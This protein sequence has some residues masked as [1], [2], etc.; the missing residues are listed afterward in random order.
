MNLWAPLLPV[1][2][3]LSALV[4]DG[5]AQ[6]EPFHPRTSLDGIWEIRRDG[7]PDESYRPI[8]V[9]G[10]FE[11]V[12]GMDFDGVARY[13]RTLA[14]PKKR[15]NKVFAEFA[16]VATHARVLVNGH[17]VKEHLGGW[18]P[19]RA[20]LTQHLKWNGKD[21]LEVIVDERVGHNTQGF[22]PIVQ[23]HFGGI[24]QG[25]TLCCSDTPT[26]DRLNVFVFGNG[27]GEVTVTTG[28]V[29]TNKQP[30][31]LRIEVLDGDTVVASQTRTDL[32]RF[33]DPLV[34]ASPRLWRPGTPHLYTA[35]LSLLI[36]DK[37]VDTMER[38]FGCRSLRANGTQVVWNDSPLQMRGILHW[39][40][41]PPA[42]APPCDPAY[43]RTQLEYFQSLGFNTIKCCLWVP[44]RGF[45][46]L[47]DELGMLV[48][49]EY[50]T[51]HAKMDQDHKRELLA[52]YDEFFRFDRSHPSVAFR[53]ITCE[54][55]KGADL[56][57]VT[58]LFQA[59]KTMVPDTLVV[60]DSS[61]IGWQ[62]I[63]DFWDEHPY[64]NNS[65]FPGRLKEFQNHIAENGE[66]PLLLGECIAA[67]TWVDR[68]AWLAMHGE[69]DV[70]WR[71]RC[72]DAQRGAEAWLAKEFG[73]DL[74][75]SLNDT[76]L[77]FGLRNRR[78]QIE[79]LRLKI[80][81]AGYVVSVA[82]D[83]PKARMG[84]LDDLNRPKWHADNWQWHRDTMLCLAYGNQRAIGPGDG[85]AVSI[86][87]SHFGT[88]P[89][90]G[91]L[92]AWQVGSPRSVDTRH[93][94]I[95]ALPP[96]PIDAQTLWRRGGTARVVFPPLGPKSK[97]LERIRIEAELSGTHPMKSHWHLWH[98]PGN[99][100][101]ENRNDVIEAEVL[102][103]D[104]IA[105]MEAGA[106][107]FLRVR[108]QQ[109]SL[110]TESMWFLKGA[111]FAPAHA[112]HELLPA[113]CLIET[114]SFDLESGRVIPWLPWRE[115][116]DPILAFWETHDIDAVRF[117]LH[118]FDTRVGK[119]RLMATSLKLDGPFGE[120]V[121]DLMM[122]HL[123]NGS[124]PRRALRAE[125]IQALKAKLHE[126]TIELPTWRF[127]MD[128][129]NVGQKHN[130]H[131]PQLDATTDD[132]R[133]LK[134]GSH[135]ENQGEDLKHFTGVGWYRVDVDVPEDW[136][137]IHAR[138]VLDGVD[139]SFHIWLNGELIGV[140]GDEASKTTIWL[141]QQVAE[142]QQRLQPGERNTIVLRVVDHAGAG[143][144]WKP[145]RLTTGPAGKV[146]NLLR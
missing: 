144:L 102:T 22:L 66:K 94:R 26:L 132:W 9:P 130:W 18:T 107:V 37:P 86:A 140:F 73:S 124:A 21:V 65:W 91:K 97:K 71:P 118:A 62:R 48:W 123:I 98:F 12:L 128:P 17:Q 14:L 59:C 143:G 106:K 20:D 110:R 11:T 7:E 15:T 95:E 146:S 40:Y 101:I 90:T 108:D 78:F 74:V 116:V 142:L 126:R 67:D 29:R 135:W 25:V 134:A 24:W 105:K 32:K 44:P 77:A 39:G 70:W 5:P 122:D 52:E 112:I 13:R 136:R 113:Q 64:G 63:T 46:E 55:G 16:A 58:A 84:L 2:A 42:L 127:R 114:C 109:H 3:T 82:R 30:E 80:P 83:F 81:E 10:A 54:T 41:S 99:H 119:G 137:G 36:K 50:P 49:Q 8:H 87:V 23:P 28:I 79:Q 61:W 34:I 4:S 85:A 51:W 145:V 1:L 100:R 76:A 133:D 117:H 111:P 96:G 45:Y 92:R 68:K 104:L 56:D 35:R 69:Q 43:W 6:D 125:T 129:D 131:D 93:R 38:R 141:A 60:D 53:S 138:C 57:V 121:A 19:F 115:Q 103:A 47:C 89:L 72:W 33:Y 27:D 75:A 88:G 31:A 139:D 120:Y